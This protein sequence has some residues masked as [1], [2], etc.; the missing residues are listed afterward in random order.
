MFSSRMRIQGTTVILSAPLEID[1]GTWFTSFIEGIAVGT[2][3]ETGDNAPTGFL[4]CDGSTFSSITY[5][6]LYSYL[7]S[8][9]L[10]DTTA[11]D[12]RTPVM[13]SYI[14]Y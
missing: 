5:P 4:K 8:T 2:I 9:T 11:S 7:G 14:K 3:I 12:S 1:K 10:P 13:Y 6:D